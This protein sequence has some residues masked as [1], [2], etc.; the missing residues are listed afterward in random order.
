MATKREKIEVELSE[1][2]TDVFNARTAIIA[3][4]AG[5][6][7]GK[8]VNIGLLVG[9][10]VLKFPRAKGFVGANTY[11][12][13]SSSTLSRV[14]MELEVVYGLTEYDRAHNPSGHYVVGK[15]PPASW[16][17]AQYK[18]KSYNNIMSF[19]NGAI[20]FLGSLDQYKA[21]DGKEFAWAH[22]D[23]TK[24]TKKE[25]LT[26][27]ILGRL[28]QYGLWADADGNVIWGPKITADVAERQGLKAWNPCYIHTSPAEG[29]VDWLIDL[30]GIKPFEK[31]IRKAI[32]KAG[33]YWFKEWNDCTVVIYSTHFNEHNLPPGYIEKRMGRLSAGEILKFIFGYPFGKNGGEFYPLFDRLKHVAK[34]EYNKALPLHTAWDFNATPYVTCEVCQLEYVVKHWDPVQKVKQI[35]WAPGLERMEVLQIR[36]VKEYTL[37]EP[38]ATTEETALQLCEDFGPNNPEVL[39]NGDASGR[40]RIPGLGTLTQYQIIQTILEDKVYLPDGWLRTKK[41]NIGVFKRRD[42]MNRI[43]EGKIPQVEIVIDEECVDLIRDCEYLLLGPKGKHKEEDKDKNGIKFQKLGHTADAL[44]YLVC[45]V[46]SEYLTDFT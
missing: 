43:W 15:K 19:W 28:R 26:T 8:T 29:N 27:V 39:V 9:W 34:V 33:S 41:T 7:S 5:Q 6:G 4:I 1:P 22:L 30:L 13:L 23:E 44:E 3:D 10:M 42:L 38:R 36:V 40:G 12:Q 35:D 32:T 45:D 18:F 20:I 31:E 25:A 14:F 24:D 21:H 46:C 37:R 17:K 11:E 2:Q 16:E